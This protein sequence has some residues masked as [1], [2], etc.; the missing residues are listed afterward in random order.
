MKEKVEHNE[1]ESVTG[2]T[3]ADPMRPWE[4]FPCPKCGVAALVPYGAGGGWAY[5][6][7]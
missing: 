4:G 5:P 3:A 6:E 1:I 2:G 7:L